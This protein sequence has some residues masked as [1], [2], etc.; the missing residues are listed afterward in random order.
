MMIHNRPAENKAA[1]L[2]EAYVTAQLMNSALPGQRQ[3]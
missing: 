3:A 1:L 2:Q